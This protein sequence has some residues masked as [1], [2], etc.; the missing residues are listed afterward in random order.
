MSSTRLIMQAGTSVYG[1]VRTFP[2]TDAPYPS[3][4]S[5][6]RFSFWFPFL[7]AGTHTT[8]TRLD[9]PRRVFLVCHN[10]AMQALLIVCL[11]LFWMYALFFV[12]LYIRQQWAKL[13]A[14]WHDFRHA[15]KAVTVKRAYSTVQ[16]KRR[17]IRPPVRVRVNRRDI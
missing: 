1:I 12:G 9:H 4:R 15:K 14:R 13:Q 16:P 11:I 17:L 2:R 10:R 7:T 3:L 6:V 5:P 8:C